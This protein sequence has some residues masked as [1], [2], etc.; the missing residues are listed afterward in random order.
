MKFVRLHDKSED[1]VIDV[2]LAMVTEICITPYGDLYKVT[3]EYHFN[4]IK[5]TLDATGLHTLE[6]GMGVK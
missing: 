4:W 5:I 1:K 2:N 6:M 3:I